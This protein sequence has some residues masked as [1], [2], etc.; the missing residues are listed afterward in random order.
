MGT[1]GNET[2][3]DCKDATCESRKYEKSQ[4]CVYWDPELEM[5]FFIEMTELED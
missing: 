5:C 3:E 2:M 1:E 4:C